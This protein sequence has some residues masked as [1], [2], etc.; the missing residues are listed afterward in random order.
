MTKG[1]FGVKFLCFF[2]EKIDVWLKEDERKGFTGV[3]GAEGSVERLLP[4]D[5]SDQHL[6]STLIESSHFS[7]KF[8]IKISHHTSN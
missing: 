2:V 7:S 4:I 3:W 5:S 6:I 1:C 8:H